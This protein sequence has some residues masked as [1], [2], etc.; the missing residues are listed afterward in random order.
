LL[1]PGPRNLLTDVPGLTVGNAT[2][3]AVRSG[4]TVVRFRA[5]G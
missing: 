1:R 5:A 3:E 2:D 4:V